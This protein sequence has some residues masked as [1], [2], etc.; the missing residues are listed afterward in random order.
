MGLTERQRLPSPV[1][2][3]CVRLLL[4]KPRGEWLQ[5]QSLLA[6]DAAP[7]WALSRSSEVYRFGLKLGLQGNKTRFKT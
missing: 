6:P 7:K 2:G 5:V 4:L 1:L 3:H